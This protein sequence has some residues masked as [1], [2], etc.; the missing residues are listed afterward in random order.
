MAISSEELIVDNCFEDLMV[1]VMFALAKS[2]ETLLSNIWFYDIEL[3]KQEIMDNYIESHME[4][5]LKDGEFQLYLQPKVDMETGQLQSSEALVRWIT[6]DNQQL[7]PNQF[8][9]IFEKSGF[10]M[11]LDMYMF[12]QACLQI[13][14]WMDQGIEP[15]GISVNQSKLLFYESDYVERLNAIVQKYQVPAHLLTLEILEDLVIN[16][17]DEVNEKIEQ[18]HQIGFKVSMDDFGSGYSS[19]NILGKIDIDEL[20]IDR[21]FLQEILDGKNKKAQIILEEIIKL[22]K[23]LSISTVVEGIETKEYHD[24]VKS[25]GCHYGQGYYYDKPISQQEFEIRYM[26]ERR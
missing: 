18:L 5:A 4:Q 24:F 3:H 8:I 7:Y 25:L 26:K 21:I 22:T 9:P 16:N 14:K 12:E 17:V 11:K 1:R 13:R 19:L 2:K 10:C 15:I 23:I 20:K 6:Q